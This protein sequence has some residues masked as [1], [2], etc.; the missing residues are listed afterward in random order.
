MYDKVDIKP[1]AP[2]AC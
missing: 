2:K 1:C